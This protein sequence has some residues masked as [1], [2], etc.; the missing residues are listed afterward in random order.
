MDYIRTQK[1][2]IL[3]RMVSQ[4]LFFYTYVIKIAPPP[5]IGEVNILIEDILVNLP[6]LP[7]PFDYFFKVEQK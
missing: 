1:A 6:V 3:S 5:T 4:T 2:Q 7:L